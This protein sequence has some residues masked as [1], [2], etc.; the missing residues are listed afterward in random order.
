MPSRR[1]HLS[2]SR[3]DTRLKTALCRASRLAPR[4]P[5][6]LSTHSYVSPDW[7]SSPQNSA[8]VLSPSQA[9]ARKKATRGYPRYT[10]RDEHPSRRSC[11][12]K[13][14]GRFWKPKAILR[15]KRQTCRALCESHAPVR[16]PRHRI[17]EA[18]TPQIVARDR[19]FTSALLGK[20]CRHAKGQRI[21]RPG[22]DQAG[23]RRRAGPAHP[24]KR[25]R[26]VGPRS[27]EPLPGSAARARRWSLEYRSRLIRDWVTSL[28]TLRD[29]GAMEQFVLALPDRVG[30]PPVAERVA[31]GP[32]TEPPDR[33]PVARH[34]RTPLPDLP[35]LAVPCGA[36]A[37]RQA[38]AEHYR[39]D[40]TL[41]PDN[42]A[43][44]ETRSHRSC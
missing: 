42:G 8:I 23:H 38:G 30:N 28:Q 2:C 37:G 1:A 27:A 44:F 12:S 36:I 34:L 33:I 7:P 20:Q 17:R 19:V 39:F 26:A 40:W 16:R 24:R 3:L 22:A 13:H 41:V 43:R 10:D 9:Q 4:A 11:E 25:N 32:S 31:R 15:Q 35:D 29:L 14:Q 21:N 6:C 18:T 5:K